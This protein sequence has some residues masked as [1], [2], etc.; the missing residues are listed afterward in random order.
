MHSIFE[1][2]RKLFLGCE[3]I[4]HSREYRSVHLCWLF[5][6][7]I[8]SVFFIY[9]RIRGS[10][11]RAAACIGAG[12]AQQHKLHFRDQHQQASSFAATGGTTGTSS[13]IGGTGHGSSEKR[14]H[15]V[16]ECDSDEDDF[17]GFDEDATRSEN[18]NRFH[19]IP[20]LHTFLFYS[21]ALD[22]RQCWFA[23][24]VL[25]FLFH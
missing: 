7:R 23:L 2:A 12:M 1:G 21:S 19:F 20:T 22:K 17:A 6:G 13:G 25:P 18:G 8:P 14:K 11:N 3:I 9:G 5:R 10:R 15:R 24:A 4:A 16:L